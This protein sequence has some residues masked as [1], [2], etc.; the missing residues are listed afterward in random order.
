MVAGAITASSAATRS[1]SRAS[2]QAALGWIGHRVAEPVDDEARQ[3]VALGVDQPVER[4]VEQRLAQRQRRGEL[5]RQ[6]GA[7]DLRFGVGVED[8]CGDGRGGVEPDGRQRSALGIFQRRHGP[9]GAGAGAAVQHDLVGVDPGR[10]DASRR[11]PLGRR[12]MTG[13]ED[14]AGWSEAMSD[15]AAS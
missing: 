10:A 11:P 4:R 5:L 3:P 14:G 1:S 8:A 9:G 7:V 6:P 2:I 13:R 12:R 15:M